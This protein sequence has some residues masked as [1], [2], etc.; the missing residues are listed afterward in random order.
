M[1]DTLEILVDSVKA[2][3]KYRS[4]IPELIKNIAQ[5]ELQK[6]KSTKA[7]VKATRS[8]LH[9]I[10]GAFLNRKIDYAKWLEVFTNLTNRQ[11]N[12]PLFKQTC[13]QMMC[14]HSS[15]D[16]RLPIL[17]QFYNRILIDIAPIHSVLDLAC[18]LNPLTIPWIPLAQDAHYYACDIF[19]DMIAFLN[20]FLKLSYINGNVFG[21][22]LSH[23][24]PSHEVHLA[25]LLKTLPCLEK[26]DKQIGIK[27]LDNIRAEH[28]LVS[29][30]VKSLGGREKGMLDTYKNR[31]LGIIEGSNWK[32]QC[33]EFSTELAFLL[34]R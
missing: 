26:L 3:A 31:F 32:I 9:Q 8:R 24:I 27:L 22:D 18:G 20:D 5:E 25:L 28:I 1:N 7:A 14:F 33:F 34:S 29:Y 23:Q 11:I 12:N 13:Q 16:E 30:P 21:C 17:E 15:T 2:G 10:G 4:I 19:E 6:R